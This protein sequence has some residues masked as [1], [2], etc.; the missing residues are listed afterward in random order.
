M[1]SLSVLLEFE[2]STHK[3]H[4]RQHGA[5]PYQPIGGLT[6]PHRERLLSGFTGENEPTR[7]AR[8]NEVPLPYPPSLRA[9]FPLP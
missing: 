9:R 6:G 8:P 5:N 2:G 1:T 7:E 4:S 3:R